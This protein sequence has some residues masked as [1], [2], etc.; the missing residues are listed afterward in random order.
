MRSIAFTLIVGLAVIVTKSGTSLSQ[1]P[2]EKRL[3][4]AVASIKPLEAPGPALPIGSAMNLSGENVSTRGSV[5]RLLM[6][7]YNL[8]GFQISGLSDSTKTKW[9]DIKAK[10]E[11]VPS[12]DEARQMLQTLLND[13][14]QLKMQWE[15]R[16]MAVYN[17]VVAKSGLKLKRSEDQTPPPPVQSLGKRGFAIDATGKQARGTFA[18]LQTPN[19]IMQSWTAAPMS[20]VVDLMQGQG[21]RPVIDKT[22]L[23]GLFDVQLRNDNAPSLGGIASATG[24]SLPPSV[25]PIMEEQF[26]LKLEPAKAGVQVLVIDSVSKPSEN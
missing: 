13:R 10:A 8:S 26:G 24:P 5:F 14:F 20:F 22:N 7:A 17:L 4:F 3:S 23:T 2:A 15:T 12:M 6:A 18:I 9:Y 11:S 21:D 1:T 25:L 19:G 16:E